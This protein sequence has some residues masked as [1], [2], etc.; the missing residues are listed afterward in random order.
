MRMV[1]IVKA[2]GLTTLPLPGSTSR[3]L[4]SADEAEV[5][6]A[7]AKLQAMDPEL[8]LQEARAVGL[9]VNATAAGKVRIRGSEGTQELARLVLARKDEVL[10][11][12]PAP[13]AP[14]NPPVVPPSQDAVASR[15]EAD[16]QQEMV[17]LLARLDRV[18][19]FCGARL[20]QAKRNVLA[21]IRL[22]IR[23]EAEKRLP[24]FWDFEAYLTCI[25]RDRWGITEP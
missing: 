16:Y 6:Q 13:T 24:Q 19:A 18:E 5:A 11:L 2:S 21:M 10:P 7:R 25:L 9:D 4:C 12:L 15:S 3:R 23:G 17:R 14:P 22:Q 1:L 8:L 20:T